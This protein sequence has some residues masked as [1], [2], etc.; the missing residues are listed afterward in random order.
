MQ[1]QKELKLL[2]AKKTFKHK[3]T[4]TYKNQ[5]SDKNE[6]KNFLGTMTRLKA[7][8][9]R[10]NMSTFVAAPG[11]RIENENIMNRRHSIFKIKT[12]LPQTV[13][14]EVKKMAR[15][16]EE[17]HQKQITL[18]FWKQKATILNFHFKFCTNFIKGRLHFYVSFQYH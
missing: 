15:S 14:A 13:Q 9:R 4:N 17:W 5:K 2:S 8:V 10:L 3:N 6:R 7:T 11:Q 16:K 18:F 12:L 1:G